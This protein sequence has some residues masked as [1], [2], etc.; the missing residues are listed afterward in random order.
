MTEHRPWN[1]TRKFA[2]V[3]LAVAAVF[4]VLGPVMDQDV[5]RIVG[6]ALV[7][8]ASILNMASIPNSVGGPDATQTRPRASPNRG[9]EGT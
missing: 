2:L 9:R 4:L 5:F 8:V 3:V 7:I 6:S 1:W